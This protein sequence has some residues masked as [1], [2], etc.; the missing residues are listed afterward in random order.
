[1]KTV[2]DW[3]KKN[4]EEPIKFFL[5]YFIISYYTYINTYIS[6]Y[7]VKMKI[8][9]IIIIYKYKSKLFLLSIAFLVLFQTVNQLITKMPILKM[10]WCIGV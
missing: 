8:G 3:Y 4:Q 9:I 2:R 10:A 6:T 5:N 7:I 1:M